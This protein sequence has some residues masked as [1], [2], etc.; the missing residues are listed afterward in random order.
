MLAYQYFLVLHIVSA[1]VW[2]G[3]IPAEF[4]LSK[5]ILNSEGKNSNRELTAVWLKL[6]NL[7]GMLGLTGILISG[8]GMVYLHP[9]FGFF[10]FSADHWLV[11]KQIITLAL[12]VLTGVYFIPLGKKTRLALGAD[13][14]NNTP[15]ANEVFAT[16]K[17]LS[18]LAKIMAGLLIINFIFGI[19]HSILSLF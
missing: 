10:R 4:I 11:S 15:L 1:V 16:I 8:I 12:I 5:Y 18:G 9:V 13:L 6:L 19:L 3:M 14:T 17:K 7:S 2:L